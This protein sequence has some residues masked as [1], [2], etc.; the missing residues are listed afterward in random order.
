MSTEV[1]TPAVCLSA[2]IVVPDVCVCVNYDLG[3]SCV[4]VST[5]SDSVACVGSIAMMVSVDSV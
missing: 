3:R 1:V 4:Y 5:K 2:V